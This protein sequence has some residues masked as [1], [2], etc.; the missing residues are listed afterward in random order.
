MWPFIINVR[1]PIGA[2]IRENTLSTRPILISGSSPTS[3]S[4]FCSTLVPAYGV[5][6]GESRLRD[7]W[8]PLE[9]LPPPIPPHSSATLPCPSGKRGNI[10]SGRLL[11]E[12]LP[13]STGR[14]SRTGLT[15]HITV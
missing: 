5:D 12:N 10:L 3:A 8:A 7:N 2:S 13:S 6:F 11:P 15:G 1:R 14:L 4:N 9:S